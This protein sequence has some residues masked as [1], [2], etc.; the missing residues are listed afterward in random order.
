MSHIRKTWILDQEIHCLLIL[1]VT[2]NA[3]YLLPSLKEIILIKLC[4]HKYMAETNPDSKV[5]S[6]R[7]VQCRTVYPFDRPD[8]LVS[9]HHWYMGAVLEAG[10]SVIWGFGH[11]HWAAWGQ[12]ISG[13]CFHTNITIIWFP[14]FLL[15]TKALSVRKFSTVA[16]I[17]IVHSIVEG[18]YLL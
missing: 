6:N 11:L 17:V 13:V 16:H 3:S 7:T 5:R 15:F 12:R 14:Y 4:L 1:E 18:E 10:C 2:C 9:I 8:L